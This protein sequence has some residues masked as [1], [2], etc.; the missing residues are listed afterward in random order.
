[1]TVE[2]AVFGEVVGIS[3]LSPC[4]FRKRRKVSVKKWERVNLIAEPRSVKEGAASVMWAATLPDSGPTGGF[5]RDG[6]PL[7]W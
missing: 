5:F 7:A 1:M 6:E 4:V 2:K 3:L